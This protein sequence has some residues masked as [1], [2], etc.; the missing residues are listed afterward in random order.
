MAKKEIDESLKQALEKIKDE[1][2]EQ[3][4]SLESLIGRAN[5]IASTRNE[6]ADEA[7]KKAQNATSVAQQALEQSGSFGS[8]NAEVQWYALREQYEETDTFLR[9]WEQSKNLK[10]DASNR[11][12][13]KNIKVLDQNITSL[14][15]KL[16]K[17]DKEGIPS[18]IKEF[19]R[20]RFRQYDSLKNVAERYKPFAERLSSID[21]TLPSPP[22]I[23]SGLVISGISSSGVSIGGG[24]R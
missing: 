14:D 15:E 22:T 24:G 12:I 18:H 23:P 8:I 21:F 20:K 17:R 19:Y 5:E 7:N 13:P 9:E 10:R 6:I 16:S 3:R 1:A 4:K 2:S 11:K